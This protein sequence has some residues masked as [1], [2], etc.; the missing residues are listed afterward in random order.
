M[1][2]RRR[3]SPQAFGGIVSAYN[4]AHN[5]Y[6]TGVCVEGA[7]G[8]VGSIATRPCKE[9]KDGP[10]SAS[11]AH[12]NIIKGWGTRHIEDVNRGILR[13]S[14]HGRVGKGR[15]F[16]RPFVLNLDQCLERVPRPKLHH[17]RLEQSI[18]EVAEAGGTIGVVIHILYIPGIEPH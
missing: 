10:P 13:G 16:C 5:A 12:T 3:L 17:T 8:R 4:S 1:G 18:D 6:A 11:I 15:Q 2:R 14:P 7:K 9:R